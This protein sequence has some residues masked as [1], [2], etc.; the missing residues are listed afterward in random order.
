VTRAAAVARLTGFT[1]N[2]LYRELARER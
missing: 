1:A 2:E